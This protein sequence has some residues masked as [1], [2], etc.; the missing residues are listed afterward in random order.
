MDSDAHLG[1]RHVEQPA[2]LNDLKALVEH[3]GRI[4]GDAAAHDPGGV[5]QRLLGGDGSELSEWKLAER[6]A[7]SREPD[8]LDFSVRADAQALV[9]GV[10]L[11]VDGQDGHV[12]LAGGGGEDFAGGHH[13][14]LVGQTDGFAGQDGSMR[15]FEAGNA[16]DGGDH[17][18]GIGMRGAGDGAFGAVDHFG[19]RNAGLTETR[20]QFSGQLFGGQ[21]NQLR[22]PA[23]GL[24][25]ASSR[26][27]PAASEATW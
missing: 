8:G 10:V 7:R 26:L 3:G 22:P 1:R 18:I 21:R 12:A 19:A 25:K 9:D 23:N 13:A 11:A 6:P 27:R 14:L 17:K 2:G 5:L 24:R 20:G 15:G 16:Y 4:D